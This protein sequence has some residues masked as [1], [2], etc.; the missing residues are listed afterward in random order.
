MFRNLYSQRNR[1]IGGGLACFMAYPFVKT[2]TKF[3][4]QD[5]PF[6]KAVLQK[7]DQHLTSYMPG[8]GISGKVRQ[9]MFNVWFAKDKDAPIKYERHLVTLEDGGTISIDWAVAS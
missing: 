6:N 1:A 9:I 8:F 5:T 3:E 2:D 7:S 4:Y